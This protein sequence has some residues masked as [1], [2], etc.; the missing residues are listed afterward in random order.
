MLGVTLVYQS[1]RYGDFA[2]AG[3]IPEQAS[4]DA[5]AGLLLL[6]RRLW[7]KA[8]VVDLLDAKRWDVVGFP[9]PRRSVFVSLEARFG[10]Q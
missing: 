5:D 10:E 3:V 7:L 1:N 8:R 2:G 6:E 4:L 9:L